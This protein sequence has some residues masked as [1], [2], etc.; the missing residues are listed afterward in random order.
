[1]ILCKSIDGGRNKR[2]EVLILRCAPTILEHNFHITEDL[3]SIGTEVRADTLLGKILNA[4]PAQDFLLDHIF[5][6][7]FI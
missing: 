4:L 1:M 7:Q 6:D 2:R 3:F 5:M